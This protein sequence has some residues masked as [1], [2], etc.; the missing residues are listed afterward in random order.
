MM[1]AGWSARR[2]VCQL[3][4]SDCV[5]TASSAAIQAQVAPSLG[6]PVSS[7]TIRKRLAEEHLGSRCPLRALPL[8]PIHLLLPIGV[9]PH[10]RKLDSREME[11]G[12]I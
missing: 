8:T 4:H 6:T 12:H 1:E 9:V 2:V 11:R 5:P 3:G 10:M 7:Q